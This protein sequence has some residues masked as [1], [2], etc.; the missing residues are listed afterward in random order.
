MFRT[1]L[2][3]DFL[4]QRRTSK[5]L[6]FLAVFLIVGIIS[7]VLA[8][9]TPQLL[10]MIPNLP[11]DMAALMLKLPAPTL[12]DAI[13][14]YA[15]NASQFGVLLVIVLT[16]NAIA[17]ERERGTAAMLF[18]KPVKRGAFI[19]SKWLVG[20]ATVTIAVIVSGIACY[21]YTVVLFSFLP[22]GKYLIFNLFLLLFLGVYLS[23]ALMASALAR[24][25]STAA[26]IA[27][28]L[29]IIL[30]ILSTLPRISDFCPTGLLNWGSGL[31]GGEYTTYWPALVISLAL[32][33]GSIAIAWWH[34]ER[35]EI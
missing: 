28:G 10:K 18:S 9:Y 15:K 26:A 20:M 27:F 19:L 35:Q 23:L 16:M 2:V 32:M 17:Q 30:L 22:L 11:P 3:K 24:T 8:K 6:V 31:M 25:Q 7:P 33:F 12:K 14:Q 4:E 21:I 1:L 34:L 5:L 13:D 29:L